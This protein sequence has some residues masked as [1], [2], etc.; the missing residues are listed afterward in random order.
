MAKKSSGRSRVKRAIQ[1]GGTLLSLGLFL[2]LLGKQNW[3]QVWQ[4]LMQMP[5]WSIPL[6]FGLIFSGLVV[7]AWRWR[8]L[9][10]AQAV[11]I[12][13]AE[14]LKLILAGAYASNFLPSTIGGDIVRIVGLLNHVSDKVMVVS[15]VVMD[16]AINV[17]SYLSLTPLIF[18]AFDVESLFSA[19]AGRMPF[20]LGAIGGGMVERLRSRVSVLF[21]GSLD[22][23]GLWIHVPWALFRALV[24]SWL[25]LLVVFL[26]VWVLARGIRI[27][28][29]LLDVIAVSVIVYL[30]TLLPISVNGY[31]LREVAVTTLYLQLGATLEQASTLAI[32]TRFLSLMATLPG[33]FWL[34]REVFLEPLERGAEATPDLPETPDG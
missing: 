34:H 15:S 6:A 5:L 27:P 25:S 21:R 30:L 10:R 11:T 2:W 1:V 18:A 22:A 19:G 33:A 26:G 17:V 32:V 16:R 4:I 20:V 8:T 23:F 12:S 7:N 24:I 14:T 9:L 28:V 3:G 29:S 13:F 31:G